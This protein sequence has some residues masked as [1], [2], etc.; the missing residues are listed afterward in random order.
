[1]AEKE[2]R[3]EEKVVVFV[4]YRRTGQ[5][6]A[7]ALQAPLIN[8]DLVDPAKRE[9][10]IQRFLKEPNCPVLVMGLKVED[11]GWDFTGV[12]A[13]A[14]AELAYTPRAMALAEQMVT[15][16]N[17]GKQIT[18]HYFVSANSI[19]EGCQILLEDKEGT[20]KELRGRLDGSQRFSIPERFID[21]NG[22]KGRGDGISPVSS[23][24]D[25]Y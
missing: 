10:Q 8:S 4:Y 2:L 23:R 3:S 25:Y 7:N 24:P 5:I 18:A 16:A 22:L 13:I 15:T 6:I 14:F 17:P 20:V 11:P 9:A 19:D 21:R 12:N 1:M